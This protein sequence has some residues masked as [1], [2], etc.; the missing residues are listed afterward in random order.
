M[1]Y[2]LLV[3]LFLAIFPV[4]QA[5]DSIGSRLRVVDTLTARERL[6]RNPIILRSE[7][8]SLKAIYYPPEVQQP[9]KTDESTE[10]SLPGY[11]L[12]GLAVL[13]LGILVVLYLVWKGLQHSTY[14]IKRLR[15][16]I[17]KEARERE[18]ESLA[19]AVKK[20]AKDLD[21]KSSVSASRFAAME[22][23][24]TKWESGYQQ[25]MAELEAL[26]Q[27][28]M[29]VYKVRNYPGYSREKSEAEV[30]SSFLQTERAIAGY[31]YEHFLKPL[32][33]V[34]DENK[35]SP[36]RIAAEDREKLLD[37]LVS[38]GLFY[39]EYLYLRVNELSIGGKMV[40]RIGSFEKGNGFDQTLL[41]ELNTEH[42]SRALTLR[43]ALDK[44]GIHHL[45][46]PV[47]DETNL[48][49]S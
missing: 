5:Q 30:L 42:G 17:T 43:V 48:N 40:Q 41:K 38:L 26:K 32:H 35:N 2:F 16:T 10:F 36:A 39:A 25:A 44:S 28:L 47:F 12:A 33:I 21:K 7:L 20:G 24:K 8:D 49:Q 1:K 27:Q 13:L 23:E 31:A 22:A 29:Q 9:T 45:S 15:E 46:Y 34:A 19:P 3:I 37:L 14:T 18:L 4:V 11:A 6:D